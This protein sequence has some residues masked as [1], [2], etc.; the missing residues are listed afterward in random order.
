MNKSMIINNELSLA[1]T[2]R[3]AL[4]VK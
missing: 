1:L 2:V 3:G 4:N